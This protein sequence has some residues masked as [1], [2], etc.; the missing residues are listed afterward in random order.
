MTRKERMRYWKITAEETDNFDYDENKLLNWEIKCIREPEEE[1]HFIGVFMYRN[2]TAY[3][4]ESVKGICYFYNNIDRKELPAIT[5]F[6]QNK[7]GG[8]EME[9]GD[10]I[11]LKDSKQIFSSKEI[12]ALAKE[13]ETEFNTKAVI[14]LEFEDISAEAL[15]ELGLPEAKLLPIPK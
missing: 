7:F 8:K 13:M 12:G 14:S 1:A 10:R 4:Y 15:K 3:D 5:K 6:L 11:I 2:G 9:K